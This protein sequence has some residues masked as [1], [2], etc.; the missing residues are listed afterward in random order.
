MNEDSESRGYLPT[1]RTHRIGL[2]PK[3]VLSCNRPTYEVSDAKRDTQ[4]IWSRRLQRTKKEFTSEERMN[5]VS[6]YTCI[7]SVA[8]YTYHKH[9]DYGYHGPRESSSRSREVEEWIM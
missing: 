4:R 3:Y 1:I 6:T 8:Q 2:Q 5:N 7:L 9:T